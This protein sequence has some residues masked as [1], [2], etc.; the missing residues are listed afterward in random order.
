MTDRSGPDVYAW[1]EVPIYVVVRKR[2]DD[3]GIA[4]EVLDWPF[5]SREEAQQLAD[6]VPAHLTPAGWFVQEIEK[7]PLAPQAASIRAGWRVQYNMM[8]GINS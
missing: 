6:N 2:E 4:C 7:T 5:K 3:N 8:N 1:N